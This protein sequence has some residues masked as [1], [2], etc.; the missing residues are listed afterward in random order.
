MRLRVRCE[1]KW[2][3]LARSGIRHACLARVVRTLARSR[4]AKMP[5]LLSRLSDKY[6]HLRHTLCASASYYKRRRSERVS[7]SSEDDSSP[8]FANTYGYRE[9]VILPLTRAFLRAVRMRA[10]RAAVVDPS[11]SKPGLLVNVPANHGV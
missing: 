11:F 4:A 7:K 2:L 6:A 10:Y 3:V 5:R 9:R 8:L 1:A